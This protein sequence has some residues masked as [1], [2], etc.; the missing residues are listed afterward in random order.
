MEASSAPER[1][2]GSA[3]RLGSLMPAAGHMVHMPAHIYLRVGRYAD[4]AEANVRAIA[5]DEDYL[6]QCQAQGLYPISYYPHNLHFLWAAA[7]LEGRSKV[8]I[9]AALE[10]A[11]K[12]PHHHAGAL[13]WTS[14]FPV[15][16]LLA[17]ARFGRW[18]AIL[19]E[20]SPPA[21]D[22]YASGIWRYARALAF[23][24]QDRLE[25]AD[26]E[27]ADLRKV[28]SHEAFT[29][30][31]KELPL[32]T[33]LQIASRIVA[34]ELAARRGRADEA[35]RLLEEAVTIEDGIP[36]NEPP[37]WHQPP[38]QVLGALLVEAGRAVD[39]ERVYRED[40]RRFP[41]NGWSLFG[42]AQSLEAQGRGN[43]AAAV[44]GRFATAWTRADIKLTSSR[45]LTNTTNGR[46]RAPAA[47]RP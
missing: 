27:L 22:P 32:L 7:T 29:T 5:A 26:A 37:V 40:L 4:A 42:L 12:A 28:M 3:D 33:N 24:A 39:A 46:S 31:L 16:P 11:R 8:A 13:A 44:R 18:K 17:Y 41:D 45:I 20:P 43:D 35:I 25:R 10:V 19:T 38:R 47:L 21:T 1:A 6:A 15:T 9:D 23:V 14:D 30:T 34:G 36:Y 2:E